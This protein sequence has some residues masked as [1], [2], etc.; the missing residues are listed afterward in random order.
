MFMKYDKKDVPINSLL[1]IGRNMDT[2]EGN[3][4]IFYNDQKEKRDCRL[5]EEIDEE[6]V[7]QQ[8]IEKE[9]QE[10][11]VEAQLEHEN[12]QQ[13]DESDED[14]MINPDLSLNRSGLTRILTYDSSTQTEHDTHKS[15]PPPKVRNTRD[16]SNDVKS[17]CVQVSVNCGISSKM[18]IIGVQTVCK[19]LYGHEFYLTK[20]EA[21]AKDP[22]LSL[23]REVADEEAVGNEKDVEI[24]GRIKRRK[25]E[26]E[27]QKLPRTN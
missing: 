17:T 6:W 16:C 15:I 8:T 23:Y 7:Q 14:D 22:T 13:M 24:E 21:I 25:L 4:L 27:L 26:G 10:Q 9:Q 3:E 1:D 5:S 19:S 12:E 2:L 11:E 20:D 18:S